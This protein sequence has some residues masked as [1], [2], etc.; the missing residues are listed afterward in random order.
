MYLGLLYF[1]YLN[2][3]HNESEKVW[4]FCMQQSFNQPPPQSMTN[5]DKS[6]T[7]QVQTKGSNMIQKGLVISYFN[8]ALY[9]TMMPQSLRISGG[10]NFGQ[11]MIPRNYINILISLISPYCPTIA[12]FVKQATSRHTL[13]L[14]RY[15]TLIL[16]TVS[17]S[18]A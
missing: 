14:I 7:H 10:P 15:L 13:Y 11:L 12:T 16:K 5:E 3:C 6:E 1:R 17:P 2:L 18:A 4:Y 8:K 9:L